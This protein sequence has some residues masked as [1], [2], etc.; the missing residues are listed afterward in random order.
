M[1]LQT[2]QPHE[3]GR[4]YHVE[5]PVKKHVENS[6]RG[7]RYAKNHGYK[8]IDL[9]FLPDRILFQARWTNAVIPVNLIANHIRNE[10]WPDPFRLDGFR[11]PKGVLGEG[12][13]MHEM[14]PAQLDR[15]V[16]GYWPRRYHI[17]TIEQQFKL[18][19]EIHLQILM[20]PKRSP[21]WLRQE[22]WNYVAKLAE[23]YGTHVA[24]YSL[25]HECLPYAR[26]AGFNAWAI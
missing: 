4:K 2:F 3:V 17:P 18:C 8:T 20:E 10:H 23:H 7:S 15:I 12:D 25:M 9:D 1:T 5:A 22:V 21:V 14:Y 11:D 24:V 19:A 16:A 6:L 26:K 13:Q